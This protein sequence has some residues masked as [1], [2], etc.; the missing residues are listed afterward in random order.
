MVHFAS[1]YNV[2]TYHD[3]VQRLTLR[4][5]TTGS[6]DLE[7]S[8]LKVAV[9]GAYRFLPTIHN[10]RF[11]NRRMVIQTEAPVTI[12]LISYDHTGGS[13]ER[14]VTITGSSTWPANAV[15]GEVVI[16]GITYQVERRVSNTV[17][18]L[19]AEANPGADTTSSSVVWVRST[20]PFPTTVRQVQ[21]VWRSSQVYRLK[22][23]SPV[24]YPRQRKMF[25]QHG[26][27]IYYTVMP[28]QDRLGSMDFVFIPPPGVVESYEIQVD[29]I[30]SPLRNY[31]VSGIDGDITS[32]TYLFEAPTGTGFKSSLVGSLFRISPSSSLPVGLHLT[33]DGRDE[34]VWQSVVRRVVDEHTLELVEAA[35]ETMT[36]R[37]WSISD[38][39]DINPSTMLDYFE[40]L[41]FE[42]F[43]RNN[44]HEQLP[45]A[46]RL[47]ME[48]FRVAVAAEST[49]NSD[50]ER[51]LWTNLGD[52]WWRATQVLPAT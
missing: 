45:N 19:R 15:Y 3:M 21:Q 25:A 27:P 11:Y 36:G 33:I 18:T 51:D 49:V 41:C 23:S 48:A 37:G 52:Q 6:S 22:Y 30:P 4:N 17:I 31:E 46:K 29:A 34:F 42:W 26:T 47:S 8:R 35:P 50:H 20:Y 32:G 9:D 44:D 16:G 10:W 13:Y 40:S 28:S 43:T 38:V 7:L 5:G 24:E 39:I 2:F 12:D 1:W 14:Q